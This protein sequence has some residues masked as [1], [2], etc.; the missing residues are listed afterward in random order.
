MTDTYYEPEYDLYG[1]AVCWGHPCICGYADDP[2]AG[3]SDD[4]G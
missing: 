1:C 4:G 2:D 3:G